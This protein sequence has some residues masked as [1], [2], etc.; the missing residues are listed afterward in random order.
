MPEDKVL[1]GERLELRYIRL[2]QAVLWDDNPKQHDLGAL[3]AAIRRYGFQDPPKF[4][5]TLGALVYGNGRTHALTWMRRQH[6]PLPRGILRD[7]EG[8]WYLPV[9]FGLDLESQAVARAFALDHNNLTMAGGEFSP[10][11]IGRMWDQG[12]Y[13]QMLRGLSDEGLL[14]VT[15]DDEDLALLDAYVR[16]DPGPGTG[17][18]VREKPLAAPS[19]ELR[20]QWGVEVG[21]VWVIPSATIPGHIHRLMCGDSTRAT[22]VVRLLNSLKPRLMVTD[23]PYGVEYEQE[24]RSSN[25]IGRVT[26]DDRCDWGAAYALAPA[27]VAYVWHASRHAAQVQHSLAGA[28]YEH[29]AQIIWNKPRHVF[30]QGHYHWKHEPCFYCVRKGETAEW[31]GDRVQNT[32]WD[33][34]PDPDVLGGHSTQKPVECMARPIRNHAGD[35]YDPFVGT[36]TTIVAAELHGR[37]AVAME[38][39]PRYVAVALQRLSDYGLEPRLEEES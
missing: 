25:R 4:D 36:G 33:I 27:A 26:N 16:G 5:A 17:N 37:A 19:E 22:D 24:W 18:G 29:R 13:N 39:A 10:L 14:P 2:D 34:D 30:S 9:K 12:A 20:D 8:H 35:V 38:I 15:V 23:P 3:A 11:D 6:E 7:Q 32:V 21:Q 31:I 1:E 28:D